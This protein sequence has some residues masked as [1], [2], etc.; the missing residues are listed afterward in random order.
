MPL[1]KYKKL[2]S[3]VIDFELADPSLFED[4]VITENLSICSLKKENVDKY[5]WMDLV[6]KSVDQRYIEY[7][8]WNIDN[9]RDLKLR[10]YLN[11]P[12]SSFNIDLDFIDGTRLCSTGHGRKPGFGNETNGY[13]WNVL[14]SGFENNWRS[15]IA[16]IHFDSKRAKDNFCKYAYSYTYF[17]K[18]KS[19]CLASKSIAGANFAGTSGEMYFAIPQIDW[20]NIHTNQ[21]ELSAPSA[22]SPFANIPFKCPSLSLFL[23]TGKA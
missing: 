12:S 16:C 11:E 7:Y 22:D 9:N 3:H 17:G 19:D 20:S 14:K 4:A 15:N 18:D 23:E 13:K 2:Y 21:K 1:S 10:N 5:D 8:K 6:L